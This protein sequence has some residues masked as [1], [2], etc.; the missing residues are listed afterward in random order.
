MLLPGSFFAAAILPFTGRVSDKFPAPMVMVFG[1]VI[2]AATL[3]GGLRALG[4][5]RT[6][7]EARHEYE[8]E[9]R[10]LTQDGT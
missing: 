7:E 9:R 10:R 6:Y 4:K 3:F 5:A 2:I 8:D 1:L